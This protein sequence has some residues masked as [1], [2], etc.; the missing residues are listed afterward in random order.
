MVWEENEE[1]RERERHDYSSS[2][3]L[4]FY[5]SVYLADFPDLVEHSVGPT[6]GQ[7]SIDR[8]FSNLDA[9]VSGTVPPL[10]NNGVAGET[11][12][13]SDHKIAF[14]QSSLLK[15]RAFEMLKYSY[16]YYNID[17]ELEYGRWL[18]DQD[19]TGVLTANGSDDKVDEY[20]RL[21]TG[22]LDHHF[23]LVTVKQKS[24]DPPWYDTKIRKPMAQKKGIYRREGHSP[25]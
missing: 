24:T 20:Q 19:W 14:V 16:M 22:A 21:V 6:R 11:S 12:K 5:P 13:K 1:E 18:A 23:P 3:C 4:L 17:S 2:V 10:E 9:T 15:V 8:I 7:R 25:K